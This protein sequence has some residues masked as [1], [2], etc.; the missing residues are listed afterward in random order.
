MGNPTLPNT[1]LPPNTWVNLYT[2][3]STAKGSAVAVGTALGIR[4]LS[5][6]TIKLSVSASAP[7]NGG[8][9]PLEPGE[10]AENEPGDVGF[11]ALCPV[12]ATVNLREA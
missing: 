8:Y 1:T 12:E 6:S 4:H 3:I 10:Y 7:T 9:E 5:D 11:W 2:A